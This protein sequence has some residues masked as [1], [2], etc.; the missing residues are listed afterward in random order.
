MLAE[1]AGVSVISE[2]V[3][4]ANTDPAIVWRPLTRPRVILNGLMIWSRATPTPV[5]RAIVAALERSGPPV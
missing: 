5:A 3:A 4:R 1:G 2:F